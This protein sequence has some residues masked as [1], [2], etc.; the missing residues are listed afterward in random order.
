M[1]NFLEDINKKIIDLEKQQVKIKVATVTSIS[2]FKCKFDG[3]STSIQYLKTKNYT[4]SLNDRV[5]FLCLSG[6][7]ICLGAYE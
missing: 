2:P 7:Y 1:I 6:F 4:P 5:Y 3:E